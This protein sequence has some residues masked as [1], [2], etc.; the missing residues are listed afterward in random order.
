MLSLKNYLSAKRQPGLTHLDNTLGALLGRTLEGVVV[1][2][3]AA[4]PWDQAR[5]PLEVVHEPAGQLSHTHNIK[6][7]THD[8]AKYDRMSTPSSTIAFFM[9]FR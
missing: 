7:T 2:V 5:V 6:W 9:A 3:D 1:D 4:K 8:Q